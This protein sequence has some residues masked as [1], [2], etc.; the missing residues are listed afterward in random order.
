[1]LDVANQFGDAGT[2]K[3]YRSLQGPGMTETELLE[4]MADATVTRVDDNLKAGVR[5]RRARFLET[6]FLSDM[7]FTSAAGAQAAGD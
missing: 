7:P 5:T 3:L 2:E 1:M 6:P 4:G